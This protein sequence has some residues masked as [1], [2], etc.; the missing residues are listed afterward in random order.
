[1]LVYQI[2][3]KLLPFQSS[4]VFV[5]NPFTIFLVCLIV[6]EMDSLLWQNPFLHYLCS[7]V[8]LSLLYIV[9]EIIYTSVDIELLAWGILNKDILSAYVPLKESRFR[10]DSWSYSNCAVS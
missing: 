10:I 4:K 3:L 1:M 2:L 5:V 6:T 8:K 7:R 9:I